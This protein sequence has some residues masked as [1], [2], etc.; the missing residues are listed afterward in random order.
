MLLFSYGKN[1]KPIEPKIKEVETPIYNYNKDSDFSKEL[2][3]VLLAKV[4]ANLKIKY[5]D[6]KVDE[7]SSINYNGKTTFFVISYT[8][9]KWKPGIKNW[10]E[11]DGN[12]IERMYVFVNR[13]NGK[14]ICKEIDNNSSY[15]ENEAVRS[16]KT[17]I[18]DK[19]VQLNEANNGI[20]L[21]TYYS[22]NNHN[23]GYDE[24]KFSILTLIGNKII[25]LVY[26]YPIEIENSD[27]IDGIYKSEKLNTMISISN[28]M[29]NGFFDLKVSKIF[30]YEEGKEEDFE[31]ENSNKI[32]HKSKK[33]F[34][35]LKY[36]GKIY[37]FNPEDRHRFL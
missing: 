27:S 34:Q 16:E 37:P 3:L 1:I 2:D 4:A 7:T 17:E 36:N 9:K 30:Q 19:F 31:N 24:T 11:N 12:F 29:T 8:A 10:E 33:E 25:K 20:V 6:V 35:V 22:I 15:Y 5:K 13:S 26:E 28:K 18:F 23:V 32:I 14:I 21:S